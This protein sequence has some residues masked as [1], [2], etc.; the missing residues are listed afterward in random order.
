ML[1]ATL[2]QAGIAE[3]DAQVIAMPQPEIVAAWKRGD[4]DGGF[5][6]DPALAELKKTGTCC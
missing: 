3:K 4:I 5:V 6:W 1:L 2:K